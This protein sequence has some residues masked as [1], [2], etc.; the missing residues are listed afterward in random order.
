M[1]LLRVES[2]NV[3]IAAPSGNAHILRDVGFT[4]ERG[5]TLGIVG[6]SGCGKTMTALALMGLLP[7]AAATTGRIEFDG[8]DLLGLDEAAW[9][10]LRGNRIA[11]IFQEPASALNPLQPIGRQVAEGLALHRG[12]TRH[13]SLAEAERLLDRVGI[14]QRHKRLDS[15][16]HELSGGQRQRVLIAMALACNP[17]LL[18]ADEPTSALDVTV[19]AQIL[20]LLADLVAELGMAL[21]LISHDLGVI[22]EACERVLVMYAGEIV[23]SASAAAFFQSRAHPYS[24]ALF[25]ALPRA[26]GGERARLAAI[27][28]FVPDPRALPRG[29]AFRDRCPIGTSVCETSRP[30]RIAVAENHFALCHFPSPP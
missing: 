13:S 3:A 6:E 17:A 27:S 23:E 25:G 12:M 19:Q 15:F 9:C 11:M 22:G 5:S 21:I 8:N 14:P 10:R 28:G 1:P 16:P 2:L 18:I 24:Q 26:R 7:D 20:D 29:C 4:L 30:P